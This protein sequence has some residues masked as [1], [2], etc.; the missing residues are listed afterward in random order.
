MEA[1]NLSFSWSLYSW[2]SLI[3]ANETRRQCLWRFHESRRICLATQPTQNNSLTWN[4]KCSQI[5]S[6]ISLWSMH[7]SPMD[8]RPVTED[9][10]DRSPTDTKD[11]PQYKSSQGQPIMRTTEAVT[12]DS[13]LVGFWNQTYLST[14]T[15]PLS[16]PWIGKRGQRKK[17]C[18]GEKHSERE[19]W[20]MEEA[21]AG[22]SLG[23]GAALGMLCPKILQ[24]SQTSTECC[25]C[26]T[27]TSNSYPG[28]FGYYSHQH[29]LL[30]DLQVKRYCNVL[31]HQTFSLT[32]SLPEK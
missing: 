31:M 13:S 5:S 16:T 4:I 32:G 20:R 23:S 1:A 11:H 10:P 24:T 25:V 18:R 30:A 12:S 3:L 2:S 6:S 21:E 28:S 22:I 14:A 7:L 17:K 27:L 26:S 19:H 29:L 9:L 15:T 8:H